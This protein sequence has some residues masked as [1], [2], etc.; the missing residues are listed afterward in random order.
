MRR[1]SAS[2][3]MPSLPSHCAHASARMPKRWAQRPILAEEVPALAEALAS[4]GARLFTQQ[5]ADQMTDLALQSLRQAN[6]QG[7]AGEALFD[8]AQRLNANLDM[9]F[10]AGI[11][12][13]TYIKG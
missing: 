7:E 5:T 6:P 13:F 4:E 11:I 12:T 9:S 10:Q 3:I 1:A 8:L 2:L